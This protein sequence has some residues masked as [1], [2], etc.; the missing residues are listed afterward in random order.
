ML[1]K[2][3]QSVFASITLVASFVCGDAFAAPSVRQLGVTS[4][5]GTS[6]TKATTS[7]TTASRSATRTTPVVKKVVS[8]APTKAVSVKTSASTSASDPIRSVGLPVSVGNNKGSTSNTGSVSTLVHN[9]NQRVQTL[10]NDITTLATQNDLSD[11]RVEAAEAIISA[12]SDM[13]TNAAVSIA[14]DEATEGLQNE[15]QVESKIN[16]MT[17]GF[18]NEGQV[19]SKI[20]AM[21]ADFQ[22]ADQVQAKIETAT[23]GL[24]NEGQVQAK[25]DAAT[26]KMV[27]YGD[28]GNF[29][30]L[31]DGSAKFNNYYT[32]TQVN[33]NFVKDNALSDKFDTYVTNNNIA[34][35]SDIAN[36]LNGLTFR[37]SGDQ[38][39]SSLNGVDWRDVAPMSVFGGQPGCTRDIVADN[40]A[41]TITI[42]GC[43]KPTYTIDIPE[44]S[45][46]SCSLAVSQTER[47]NAQ[48]EKIGTRVSFTDS[49]TGST[50]DVDIDDGADG[51]AGC[52]LAVS[53]TERKNAQ[54]Q[55]IGTRVS[56]T[57]SCTGSTE[58]VDIDDGSD[59]ESCALSVSQTERTNAQGQRIGT[60]VSFTNPC[61]NTTQDVDIDDGTDGD[62]GCPLSVSQSVRTNAQGQRIGTRVS[63]TNP[64]TNTT[65]DVDIDDGSQAC[66]TTTVIKDTDANCW[67][68]KTVDCD[69]NVSYGECITVNSEP[70]QIALA[71]QARNNGAGGTM[72]ALVL[73]NSC[74]DEQVVPIDE[75][76]PSSVLVRDEAA[77]CWKKKTTACDGTVTYGACEIIN[78]SDA[79]C[80][81]AIAQQERN[82][83]AGGT[84]RALVLTNSCDD[85]E[86][87]VPLDETC[88]SSVMVRDEAANCWKKKTTACDGTV[89]YGACITVGSCDTLSPSIVSIERG[90]GSNSGRYVATRCDGTTT[91]FEEPE[92]CELQITATRFSNK[93]V[94]DVAK[95][96][97][98]LSGRCEGASEDLFTEDVYDAE[99]TV[100]DEVVQ[101]AVT[102]RLNELGLSSELG[103][104]VSEHTQ[105][106]ADLQS[107][108][109]PLIKDT[110]KL[111][112]GL[113]AFTNEER[114]ALDSG[115]TAAKVSEYDSKT[116]NLDNNGKLGMANV[117]GLASE[118]QTLSTAISN[119][120]D[121]ISNLDVI[122][123][124]ATN[125]NTA[126]GYF[127]NELL[128]QSKV[129]GLET[130]LS[131]LNSKTAN[132]TSAGTL[133]KDYVSGLGSL[134][135]KDSVSVSDVSGLGS[136][137]TKSSVNLAT[138]TTG[139]L[140]YTKVSGLGS[141]ATKDSV[142]ASDVSGLGALAIKN[143]VDLSKEATGTLPDANMPSGYFKSSD[144]T[145]YLTENTTF[146][147]LQSSVASLEGTVGDST[148]GLVKGVNDLNGWVG[149]TPTAGLRGAVAELDLGVNGTC[150]EG[151]AQ[152]D[153]TKAG[154]GSNH[155]GAAGTLNG[156]EC[157]LSL[158]QRIA[159]IEEYLNNL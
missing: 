110:A 101:N 140:S 119:K 42:S 94:Q 108:K 155:F 124:Y 11:L 63:F 71:Q 115:I 27:T 143:S 32:K 113:V 34:K 135:T 6:A 129:S 82:N 50:Q 102:S 64:C 15:Q 12:T 49:C 74:D 157:T 122:E 48:G 24:Q 36:G 77:D 117:S 16:A 83:G 57:N 72:R 156:Q 97:L 46:E 95:S 28:N 148:K 13:A 150:G 78:G 81:I 123:T 52:D 2:I 17:A 30:S 152:K 133:S 96:G 142:S 67:K 158:E 159:F 91:D 126:Y 79:Q 58:D 23:A 29:E 70:C 100:D 106:I 136:L 26:S 134:A 1:N 3:V 138:D 44:G 112:S 92:Q 41:H 88:P 84:M 18:Q 39:Q 7:G 86:Q 98:T 111:S 35:I 68:N 120:Q 144:F 149:T 47:K 62:G 66:P 145:Q 69:G 89:T 8:S 10:E 130:A 153:G 51:E 118:L 114:A 38:F 141:L 59:G 80:Q 139:N 5:S 25:I 73:T 146:S 109:Q 121:I 132:L 60:R 54:G 147:G 128:P 87:T 4:T 20:A 93:M 14:I 37:A 137:A 19:E 125:G 22:D 43:D 40:N 151:A 65:E 33:N 116:A 75:R 107:G 104:T 103:T 85:E 61:T 99:A 90:T 53:Q 21:T 56:F 131:D 31:L 76:C 55:R 127:D 105:Q 9:M 45:S 154:T